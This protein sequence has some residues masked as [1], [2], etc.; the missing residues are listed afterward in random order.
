MEL[1]LGSGASCL[2]C[3]VPSSPLQGRQAVLNV[4]HAKGGCQI[5]G[6]CLYVPNYTGNHLNVA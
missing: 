2:G 6:I 3:C 1:S 4:G 5:I